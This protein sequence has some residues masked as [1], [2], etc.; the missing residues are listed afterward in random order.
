MDDAS[1]L[2]AL[3]FLSLLG[4]IALAIFRLW[5]IKPIGNLRMGI[6]MTLWQWR[7][8]MAGPGVALA[9]FGV[10]LL[11]VAAMPAGALD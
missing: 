4:G 11:I 6:P 3:G 9:G 8:R 2:T 1:I 10:F 7:L 5:F